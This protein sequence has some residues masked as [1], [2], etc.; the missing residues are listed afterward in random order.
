[1]TVL[2]FLQAL[3]AS[4]LQLG[5][6]WSNYLKNKARFTPMNSNGM[7]QL[8]KKTTTTTVIPPVFFLAS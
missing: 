6:R 3:P 8:N 1:M 4:R 2:A 5:S 7:M